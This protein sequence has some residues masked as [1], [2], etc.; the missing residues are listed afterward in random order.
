MRDAVTGRDV[1]FW[2]AG[3]M[4]IFFSE[5]SGPDLPLSFLS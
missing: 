2:A 5:K 3:L 4:G 1:S